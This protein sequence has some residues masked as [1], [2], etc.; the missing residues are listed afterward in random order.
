MSFLSKRGGFV[1]KAA[2]GVG[3]VA[4]TVGKVTDFLQKPLSKLMEPIAGLVDKALDK[5]PFGIG[6]FVKPFADKFMNNALSTVASG[7]LGGLGVLAKAMPTI[8]KLGDRAHQ[9]S[10]IAGKVG[11]LTS[12]Q[13][14]SNSRTSSLTR[15]PPCSSSSP[16]VSPTRTRFTRAC[17]PMKEAGPERFWGGCFYTCGRGRPRGGA[18]PGL[19][20]GRSFLSPGKRGSQAPQSPERTSRSAS[21]TSRSTA[22]SSSPL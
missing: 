4:D 15:R 3:T 22:S 17:L 19:S 10:D 12:P 20:P 9:V 16:L 8:G 18:G 1:S 5:L 11:G 2:G 6:K 13:G 7:P 21:C 14:P